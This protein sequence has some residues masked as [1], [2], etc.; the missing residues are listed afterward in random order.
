M[1]KN[2][3][4]PNETIT[5]KTLAGLD[6]ITILVLHDWPMRKVQTWVESISERTGQKVDFLHVAGRFCIRALNS[7]K[8]LATV[9][10]TVKL[11]LPELNREIDAY[12]VS[13]GWLTTGP[14]KTNYTA[15]DI[16]TC[17]AEHQSLVSSI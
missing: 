8:T 4:F 6:G 16:D 3:F 17:I 10:A 15:D 13:K 12:K 2:H 7:E 14:Y 5:D 9:V 11:M 1:K